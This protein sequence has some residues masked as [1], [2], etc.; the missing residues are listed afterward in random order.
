MTHD[1]CIIIPGG[2]SGTELLPSGS[3]E[4]LFRGHKYLCAWVEAKEFRC[5]LQRQMV[6]NH[7]QGFPAQP[8]PLALHGS[9]GHLKGLPGSHLMGQKG[10]SPVEYMGDGVPLMGAEPD[11]RI[12]APEPDVAAVVLTGTDGIEQLIVLFHQRLPALGILPD[13][14]PERLPDSLL[15]LLGKGGLPLVEDT[16]LPAVLPLN[17]V[18]D[19][20]VPEIQ[21]V[22]QY[23]VGVGPSCAEGHI[24]RHVICAEG[25]LPLHR[26]F[27]R[28]LRILHIRITLQ[29][30]RRVKGL[31]HELPDIFLVN[32][33]G[34]QTHVDLRGLQI[35]GLGL[36]QRR[37]VH[38]EATVPLGC[39]PGCPQLVP[40]VPG[41]IFV[42][43][44]PSFLLRFRTQRILEYDPLKLPHN[45]PV[46]SGCTQQSGHEGQVHPA[47]LPNGNP[48]CLAGR[49]H[50]GHTALRPD[51]ALG[52]HI[53]LALQPPLLIQILQRA[54]QIVGRILRK[55]RL[56]GTAVDQAVLSR[57]TLIGLV[58]LPL[59]LPDGLLRVILHLVLDQLVHD[60]PQ[61]D[62]PSDPF[63]P[64]AVSLRQ[65]HQAVLP[66]I[67]PAV[68]HTIGKVLHP[69][70]RRNT[71]PHALSRLRLRLQRLP[72]AAPHQCGGSFQ[73]FGKL[74]SGNGQN[75]AFLFSVLTAFQSQT[76]Q[77]HLRVGQKIAVQHDPVLRLPKMHPFFLRLHGMLPFLQKK[78]VRNHLRTSVGPERIVGEPHRPQQQSLSGKISA[79]LRVF[80]IHGTVAGD[81]GH[82]ASGPH[83]IQY[84]GKEIIVDGKKQFI[85]RHII[86]PIFPKRHIPHRTDGYHAFPPAACRRNSLSP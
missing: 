9:G 38:L 52:E 49:V 85:V 50:S 3:L 76:S 73:L 34:P 37:H 15:L 78:D 2:D 10:I 56:V 20:H 16:L 45:G 7:E 71:L 61:P 70:I 63:R 33:C 27:S 42:P 30:K 24:G 19:P 55:C 43:G 14:V 82:Y 4:I 57:K 25:I 18:I 23:L 41:Q 79:H 22:L 81:K 32:P 39:Q 67:H 36:L 51:G 12:H 28:D 40:D 47:P 26:P 8:Q 72:I 29:I 68:H 11:V 84:F 75:R 6:G 1:H 31:M 48:K 65:P 77:H 35:L 60:L 13:P 74:G 59:L 62:H 86:Y 83:L 58:Q 44:A 17:R 46:L 21:A 69:R 54:E 5:P 64:G 80:G 53:R 66:E